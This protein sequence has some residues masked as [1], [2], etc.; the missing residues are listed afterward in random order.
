MLS[1][2]RRR[3]FAGLILFAGLVPSLRAAEPEE[4][5]SKL[6][7]W[8]P[9]S[10]WPVV[11]IHASLLPNGKV[12]TWERN[13]EPSPVRISQ[14]YVW[15]PESGR[16]DKLNNP[17]ADLFCSGHTLLPDGTL[18]VAGGHLNQ[19]G[20]GEKAVS[21]FDFRNPRKWTPGPSMNAGRWYPSVC[22]LSTGEAL[23]V[24]G[25]DANGVFNDLPQI[26][27]TTGGWRDLT[28]ARRV[29]SFYPWTFQAPNGKVFVAGPKA[30]TLFL[31]TKGTGAWSDGP[32]SSVPER[33][34][35]SA[36]MYEPGKILIAGGSKNP[37]VAT[38]ETLDLNVAPLKWE[39]TP[40]DMKFARRHMNATL[41]ADGTVLVTG[42]TSG[43]EENDPRGAVLE[44]ELWNPKTRAWT[45][46]ARMS[47]PR[48]YHSTAALLLPDGRVL[49]AGGGLPPWP[50]EPNGQHIYR[51][52]QIFEPP[53]L[54]KGPRPVIDSAP[55]SVS[56][57]QTFT[58]RTKDAAKIEKASWVRLWA[59]SLTLSTRA[60]DSTGS[61][62]LR[63]SR[64]VSPSRLRLFPSSLRPAIT[65]SSCSIR[66]AF[67]RWPGSSRS[68]RLP[69]RPRCRTSKCSTRTEN[70]FISIAT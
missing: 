5:A 26:W 44:A 41:L 6:G 2:N 20:R 56:Y 40:T 52:A 29:L 55:E 15:D 43:P 17:D 58:V 46:M 38:A 4:D 27:K 34:Y 60:S 65:C 21:F 33:E 19:D 50:S 49:S 54:F 9:V 63:P 69:S 39:R 66:T 3:I 35:G 51:N 25:T 24:S 18:L 48:L 14:T 53:Y 57:G 13:E 36:V 70:G 59:P 45:V 16:F 28:S 42:G 7:Q 68:R 31:D 10:C 12:L 8:S 22:A 37:V 64:A 11:A 47:V 62:T 1:K 67:P 32:R 30:Q 23:V 61:P